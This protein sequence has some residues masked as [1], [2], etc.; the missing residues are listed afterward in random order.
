MRISNN[1]VVQQQLAGLTQNMTALQQAS[2]RVTTGKQL[3]EASD[4]PLAATQ[5]MASSTSLAALDQYKSNVQAASSRVSLE[6]NILQQIGDL[7]TRAKEL[8]IQEGTGTASDATHAVASA[9]MQQLFGQV[10]ALGN[11][12]IGNEYLFGGDQSLTAPFAVSGAGA[13]TDYSTTNP[14]GTRTVAIDTGQ[15]IAMSN[16]GTQLLITT[17]VLDSMKQL[18]QAMAAGSP[19]Y[20]QA[21]I[22]TAAS[23]LDTAFDKVQT[24]VGDV[25]ARGKQLDVT[26]QNLD[27]Y[28]TNL[29]TFKSNLQ[30]VDMDTAVTELTNR[31]MAYQAAMLATSKVMGLTLTDYL[32]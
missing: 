9:E 3:L 2:Q 7:V 23:A 22:T 15:S 29:T 8:A 1:L 26:Q 18:A 32:K 12:K 14:Q 21:G 27:A 16:D 4:D 25:G 10:V 24:L 17:G 20:G 19:T 6:D 13:N 11:T 28:K 31:Q 30:D 5:V